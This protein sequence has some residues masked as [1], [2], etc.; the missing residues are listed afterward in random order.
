MIRSGS[1]VLG[2]SSVT[3]TSS[4]DSLAILPMIGRLP[5]S[6]SPPQPKTVVIFLA[7]RFLQNA[8]NRS[9]ASGVW[10]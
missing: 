4:L 9:S 2:L 5:R 6:L 10:A 3:Y 7:P 8:S 1:S